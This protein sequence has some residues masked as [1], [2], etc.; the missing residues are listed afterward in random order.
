MHLSG[1]LVNNNDFIHWN[2]LLKLWV[3]LVIDYCEIDPE[4]PP[5]WQNEVSN[6]AMLSTAA[7]IL[8]RASIVDSSI[9]KD[10]G[11]GRCDLYIKQKNGNIECIEAKKDRGNYK[12]DEF[13]KNSL[14]LAINDALKINHLETTKNSI[15]KIG[16]SFNTVRSNG[17]FTEDGL[18]DILKKFEKLNLDALAWVFPKGSRSLTNNEGTFSPGMVLLIKQAL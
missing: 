6:T 12:S 8:G 16:I 9:K 11:N 5:W 4:D 17:E 3:K 18:Q 13:Y 10:C 14:D 2:S 7:S 1:Y 15:K